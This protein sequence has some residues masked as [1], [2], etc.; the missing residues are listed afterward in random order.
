MSQRNIQQL[1]RAIER[2]KAEI[3]QLGNLRPGA[4]TQQYSVCG[5]PGCRCAANPPQ[6]HGPYYQLSYTLKKK[7]TT[8]FVR[9]EEVA[10]IRKEVQTYARLKR[11]VERWVELEAELS[12][13]KLRR[14]KS[15]KV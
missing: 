2:A 13:L 6:K 8:R 11:R 14:A 4:L 7:S 9:K 12:D 5:T 15:R 10:R 3:L 1:E